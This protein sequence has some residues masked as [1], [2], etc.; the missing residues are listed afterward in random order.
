MPASASRLA[1]SSKA[2]G[3]PI[4]DSTVSLPLSIR[5]DVDQIFAISPWDRIVI[6][7]FDFFMPLETNWIPLTII[8]V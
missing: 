2:G 3:G 4:R 8:L 5:S 6:S 1:L 7:D